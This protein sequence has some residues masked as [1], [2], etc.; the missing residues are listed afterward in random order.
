[1]T[2]FDNKEGKPSNERVVELSGDMTLLDALIS[3]EGDA[4][5]SCKAGLCTECAVLAV[6]GQQNIEL[7]AAILDPDTTAK[8]FVLSCSA[9]IKGA[10]VSL[11]LGVGDAMY[12]DQFGSFRKDHESYQDGGSNAGN[13]P[14]QLDGVFNLNVE[15]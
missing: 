9:R 6:S 10:G 2:L 3:A 7:E 5:H 12:E 4:P 1:V 15:A 13:R 8:G 11:L 14:G